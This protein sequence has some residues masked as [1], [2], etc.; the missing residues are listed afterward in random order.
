MLVALL[1]VRANRPWLAAAVAA[2]TA[3]VSPV[4]GA[5]LALAVVGVLVHDRHRRRTALAVTAA[6][7]VCLLFVV[8]YFATPGPEGFQPLQAWFTAAALAAMLLARPPAYIRTVVLVALVACPVVA[9]VP[10]GLGSNFERFAWI[11]LPAAV[12]ATARADRRIVALVAAFA[13][14][15]GIVGSAKDLWVAAQPMSDE[16][17]VAGLVHHL[18]SVRGLQNYRV[19]T[20]PDG[21]HVAAY[22]LL[23]HAELAGGFE[24]QAD[25]AYDGVLA[26]P[27]LD[28]ARYR[29]WLDANAVGYVAMDRR[30]LKSG[31][32]DTLV[33]DRRPSYLHRVWSDGKWALYAVSAPTPIVA[34]PASVVRSTQARLVVS[35]PGA[36]DY[37]LA[38]RWSTL[39]HLSGPSGSLRA[40][41]HGWSRLQARRAGRYVLSG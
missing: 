9:L 5:F 4:S 14:S 13:V 23:G 21:T 34:R 39:L 12:V 37:R 11:V 38:V 25:N 16:A 3:L 36:G 35:V 2:L 30:T 18:D 32:E 22:A 7:G 31:P 26:S 6:A 27:T 33:R 41:G 17:Y 19:E 20:V 29:R 28:A 1:C 8:V 40:D 15:I 24:T 10:N